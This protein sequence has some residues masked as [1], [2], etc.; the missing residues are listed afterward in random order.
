MS[1]SLLLFLTKPVEIDAQT[2]HSTVSG[3]RSTDEHTPAAAGQRTRDVTEQMLDLLRSRGQRVT[4]ARRSLVEQLVSAQD[5]LTADELADRVGSTGAHAHRATIYRSLESLERAGIIEHVH[6]GHGR[7]VYHLAD[8][9]HQHLVCE[10]CGSVTEAPDDLLASVA[11]RLHRTIGFEMR[12][13]HFAL[14]G[15]CQ[16]CAATPG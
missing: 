16:D 11:R 13:Y 5:H 7:A 14:L 8:D 6:L 2:Y 12:P 1:V 4:P 10:S 3:R 9:L 15:R